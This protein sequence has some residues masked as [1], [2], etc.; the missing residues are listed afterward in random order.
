M[1]LSGPNNV[2]GENYLRAASK[3]SVLLKS[4]LF[5]SAD[6]LSGPNE[7]RCIVRESL[8]YYH[9][10]VVGG[11][12]DFE[13]PVNITSVTTYAYALRQCVDCH[14]GLSVAVEKVETESPHHVFCPRIEL[15][16]HVQFLEPG[17]ESNMKTME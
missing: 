16:Q 17:D 14:P 8:G 12:Y 1:G 13:R 5:A 10:L 9:A 7:R 2:V 6:L 4:I 11:I 15:S 3:T